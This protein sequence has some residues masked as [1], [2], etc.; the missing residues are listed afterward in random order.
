LPI[1]QKEERWKK[2]I[3]GIRANASLKSHAELDDSEILDTG[4]A[5]LL[6]SGYKDAFQLLPGLK[7]IGGCCGTDHT[8]MEAICQKLFEA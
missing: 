2:R 3:G 4:D 8:H 7:I 6:A 1:L 5:C